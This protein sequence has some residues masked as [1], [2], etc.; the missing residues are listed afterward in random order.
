M[1]LGCW[2]VALLEWRFAVGGAVR[3]VILVAAAGA[4]RPAE[5]ASH[6]TKGFPFKDTGFH[7]G[8]LRAIAHCTAVRTISMTRAT[9]S[10]QSWGPSSRLRPGSAMRPAAPS[11]RGAIG[12]DTHSCPEQWM[13]F[14]GERIRD[15]H[16]TPRKAILQILAQQEPAFL[17]RGYRQNQRVP[18]LQAMV[19]HEVI[20]A[21]HGH[22]GRVCNR[23]HIC[24]TRRGIPH[25]SRWTAAFTAE[26]A[27]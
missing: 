5:Q 4:G 14:L 12:S 19:D 9:W 22:P 18:D 15:G 20:S 2:V 23:K 27:I 26:D 7:V 1:G 21:S 10:A 3:A 24:P 16:A 17:F 25:V 13:L 11:A 6:I 8:R